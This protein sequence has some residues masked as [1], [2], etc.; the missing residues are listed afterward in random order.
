MQAHQRVH[1]AGLSDTNTDHL[2]VGRLVR[3]TH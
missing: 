3:L 1:I 2:S